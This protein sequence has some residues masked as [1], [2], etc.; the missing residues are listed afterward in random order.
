M[1]CC[2]I[3]EKLYFISEKSRECLFKN[4]SNFEV[5][6]TYLLTSWHFKIALGKKVESSESLSEYLLGQNLKLPSY[7][8]ALRNH[9]IACFLIS[10]VIFI[11]CLEYVMCNDL[12]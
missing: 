11:V 8:I 1:S 3:R 6:L 10:S 4:Y 5:K 2:I 12:I 7:E 9:V